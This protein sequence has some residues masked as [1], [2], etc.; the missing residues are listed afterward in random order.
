MQIHCIF[1]KVIY[2][3]CYRLLPKLSQYCKMI[4]PLRLKFRCNRV[5]KLFHQR[6]KCIKNMFMAWNT[7]NPVHICVNIFCST[8]LYKNVWKIHTIF[9]Q[10]QCVCYLRHSKFKMLFKALNLLCLTII[11]YR[12]G[13]KH[14]KGRKTSAYF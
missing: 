10:M 4:W 12:S 2:T 6:L 1:S 5:K 7:K 11:L 3:I 9:S 13:I 14:S 8:C